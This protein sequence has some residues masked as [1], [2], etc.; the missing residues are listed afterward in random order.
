MLACC[1]S[2]GA[3]VRPDLGDQP[4]CAHFD[5]CLAALP[6]SGK[7]QLPAGWIRHTKLGGTHAEQLYT[8]LLASRPD[9]VQIQCF[10]VI[11]FGCVKTQFPDLADRGGKVHL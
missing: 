6:E 3:P 9:S 7:P 1:S 2:R 11:G 8:G 4:L 5:C 10:P